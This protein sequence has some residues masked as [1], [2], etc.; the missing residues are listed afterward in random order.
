MRECCRI[1]GVDAPSTALWKFLKSRKKENLLGYI[2]DKLFYLL[3]LYGICFSCWIT[4]FNFIF[5]VFFSNKGKKSLI[6][7]ILFY[8]GVLDHFFSE[9]A[10]WKCSKNNEKKSKGAPDNLS[11]LVT[12][13]ATF[14]SISGRSTDRRRVLLWTNFSLF[15]W[16]LSYGYL[17]KKWSSNPLFLFFDFIS[18]SDGVCHDGSG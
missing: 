1:R 8:K 6:K 5:Q 12:S 15:F 7:K 3:R 9:I 11:G 4:H 18:D 14:N 10:I 17:R 2:I 13:Q 16:A